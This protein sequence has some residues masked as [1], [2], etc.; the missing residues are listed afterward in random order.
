LRTD[1]SNARIASAACRKDRDGIYDTVVLASFAPGQT[2]EKRWAATVSSASESRRWA[3]R[4]PLP[5]ATLRSSRRRR[6]FRPQL[7]VLARQSVLLLNP[8]D[9]HWADPTTLDLFGRIILRFPRL[10]GFLI[11]TYQPDF[12]IPWNRHPH[13]TALLLNRLGRRHCQTMVEAITRGKTLPSD[14]MEQIISKTDGIPLFVEELTKNVLES[15]LLKEQDSTFSLTGPLPPLAKPAT[16]QDS[17]MARLDR[18]STVKEVAQVGAA[19][20]REFSFDLLAAVSSMQN[21]DLQDA[22][23]NLEAAALIFSHGTPPHASYGRSPRRLS[24]PINA[25][26]GSDRRS[27]TDHRPSERLWVGGDDSARPYAK[28]F[29]NRCCLYRIM[30][31][32]LR[33]YNDAQARQIFRDL[34][35]M[36]AQF[37]VTDCEVTVRF[38]RRAHLPIV[39]SSG[40]FDKP[41]GV[42]WWDGRPLRLHAR[43]R[44]LASSHRS[45]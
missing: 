44:A 21:A 43:E 34:I 16:L 30:A 17:L 20:G 26:R 28:F 9:A 2:T 37:T 45:R 32:R 18:P 13:V 14:V 11:M 38:Y 29:Q 27:T 19:I 22:L 1:F 36:P 8:E 7:Q 24:A 31:R 6:K 40:L 15:G 10:C 25:A 12:Q 5:T 33:G 23:A 35:D 39:V 41:T 42:P 3:S 4:S